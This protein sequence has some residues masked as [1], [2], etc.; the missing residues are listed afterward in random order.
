MQPAQNLDSSKAGTLASSPAAQTSDVSK[1]GTLASGAAAQSSDVSKA[2]SPASSPVAASQQLASVAAASSQLASSHRDLHSSEQHEALEASIAG[3]SAGSSVAPF[4]HVDEQSEHREALEVGR[5]SGQRQPHQEAPLSPAAPAIED[6]RSGVDPG[7]NGHSKAVKA[8]SSHSGTNNNILIGQQ[9]A[10]QPPQSDMHGATSPS[11]GGVGT[12]TVQF[13]IAGNSGQGDSH[14]D[15]RAVRQPLVATPA[16]EPGVDKAQGP[17][18]VDS[19]HAIARGQAETVA[20]HGSPQPGYSQASSGAPQ[21]ASQAAMPSAS[22]DGLSSS[23]PIQQLEAPGSQHHG[24][25]AR[26]EHEPPAQ[27]QVPLG[28]VR[29]PARGENLTAAQGSL[30]ERLQVGQAS[31]QNLSW[32]AVQYQ[33]S[34][35]TGNGAF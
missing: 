12:G 16:A 25:A 18:L 35:A 17:G 28:I 4:E 24:E 34:R 7:R 13:P 22:E 31:A 26:E 30:G 21:Q 5:L 27:G 2:G 6:G 10:P 33:S 8:V 29:P 15:S 1:A 19:L 3:S 9:P 32:W 14:T 11:G 23:S 20:S